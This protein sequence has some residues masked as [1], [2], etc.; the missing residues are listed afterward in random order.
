MG[1]TCCSVSGSDTFASTSIQ[2]PC[3]EFSSEGSHVRKIYMSALRDG[4]LFQ[5]PGPLPGCIGNS[6]PRHFLSLHSLLDEIADAD[7]SLFVK[8]AVPDVN[9][10]RQE[11]I[12][13]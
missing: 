11:S 12:G 3:K 9:H 7:N 6:H 13:R 5:S 10:L 8:D 2:S 4:R 1:D